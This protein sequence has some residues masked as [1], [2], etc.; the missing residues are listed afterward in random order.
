[1]EEGA[2]WAVLY[3]APAV[4]TVCAQLMF[5]SPMPAV[6]R[7]RKENNLRDL[8]V[9]PFPL[10]VANCVGWIV[11][12]E[13]PALHPRPPPPPPPRVESPLPPLTPLSPPS[14]N[15]SPG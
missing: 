15:A 13:A 10:I 12:S 3:A 7:A 11:Y 2:S 6:L 9:V 8:N 4:G 14:P 5:A 1:M